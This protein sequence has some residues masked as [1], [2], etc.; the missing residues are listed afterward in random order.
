MASK[1]PSDTKTQIL[2]NVQ[3]AVSRGC[4][5]PVVMDDVLA[6][7]KDK[8][9]LFFLRGENHPMTSP[10]LGEA[11]ESVRLLLTKNHPV[12]SP[13]F[14]AGAPVNPLA[15]S[16]KQISPAVMDDIQESISLRDSKSR[17]FEKIRKAV[18]KRHVT[19]STMNEVMAKVQA[20][21]NKS[22]IL[23]N[24]RKAVEKGQIPPDIFCEILATVQKCDDKSKVIEKV[25]QVVAK[26]RVSHSV[27]KEI[28]GNQQVQQ[29]CYNKSEIV[30]NISTAVKMGQLS[31]SVVDDIVSNVHP[32]DSKTQALKKINKAIT[33]K[34]VTP[35]IMNEVLTNI[36]D[37]DDIPEIMA[38]IHEENHAMTSPAFSEAKGS[39]R[40]LLT[41]NHDVPIPA[42]RSGAPV[43]PL[44]SP[45]LRI[46]FGSRCHMYVCKR[47]N[48][49]TEENLTI[50]KGQLPPEIL[51]DIINKVRPKDKKK[52]VIGKVRKGEKL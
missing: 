2:R 41:K 28:L 13:A 37:C 12:P 26:R 8:D 7:M 24:V 36:K 31:P 29:P 46:N 18:R 43:N 39:V 48:D 14:R 52:Q 27:L 10:A 30:K 47:T 33:R 16:K 44:H 38:N 3:K 19:P 42:F 17:V 22:D 40:L 5:S 20:S 21:R 9:T 49:D 23:N 25:R 51:G 50:E 11:R 34:H 4:L 35:F 15:I 32:A 1:K 6:R 45:Q